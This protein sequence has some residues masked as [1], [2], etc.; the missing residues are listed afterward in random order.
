[1]MQEY[2][3]PKI[4]ISQIEHGY[5]AAT[6]SPRHR[7]PLILHK[8]GADFNQV[9][10]FM[11]ANS[12][13]APHYHPSD[14][15]SEY[16]HLVEGNITVIYFDDLGTVK[17]LIK[18]E[19]STTKCIKVPPFTWHTYVILSR[20]ALTYETMFGKYDPGTWKAVARWAPDETSVSASNYLKKLKKISRTR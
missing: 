10:N 6:E 3:I 16:I 2:S 14:E 1:M 17:N 5:K 9:F 18:L 4:S 8:Q 11:L 13:M 7:F 20:K 12:Y 19:E 15:K